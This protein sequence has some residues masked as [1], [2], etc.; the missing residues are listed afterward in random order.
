M[1]Q[2]EHLL[3][4][5]PKIYNL[6]HPA[7]LEIFQDEVIVEEKVDG[8][9]FSFGV[10]NGELQCR[11]KGKK[12][13]I[14]APDKL[15]DKAVETI[16]GLKDK[17]EPGWV[18]I[19]EYLCVSGDTVVRKAAAG[20]NK[21]GRTIR[22]L[23]EI[24][25][26]GVVHRKY[27]KKTTGKVVR[28][29]TR[30]R[31]KADGKPQLQCLDINK[32]KII[33]NKFKKIIYSG[34]KET[35][36]VITR[37]GNTIRCTLDHP[38]WTPKGWIPLKDLKI[39]DCVGILDYTYYRTEKRRYTNKDLLLFKK[40]K[41]MGKCKKCKTTLSLQVH[42][43]DGNFKNNKKSNLEILC[44][45]CH[46]KL[47]KGKKTP[48]NVVDYEFDKIVKIDKHE[49][50]DC[51]DIEMEGNE[52]VASFLGNDFILHNC[53]PKHNT[54]TYP[55]VPRDHII[56]FDIRTGLETYLDYEHKVIEADTIGLEVVPLLFKGKVSGVE[57]LERLLQRK[58]VLGDISI[59]GVVVKNYKRFANDGKVLMAKFVS[60]VFKEINKKDF[61]A[62]N[63]VAGDILLA[64]KERYH[65]EARWHKSIQHLKE[66]G[67]LTETV[68][69]I[70]PLI[71]LIKEDIKE[72]CSEEIK[73]FLFNWAWKKIA[74]TL[75]HGF[76]EF[77]KDLL[78]K[79]QFEKE[80]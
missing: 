30:S 1:I 6:G 60:E 13:M 18:Y 78:T 26:T 44:Q 42:H 72:E 14:E 80:E 43:K 74:G 70:G 15:F 9:Q 68:K 38:F 54:L 33:Y 10:L 23:Y 67:K 57:E 65:S 53:K 7:I 35:Y 25:E 75:V 34:K 69:D 29:K 20:K 39:N 45:D 12:Q 47:R 79:K 31:W 22:E 61:R 66:D 52:N 76:P 17:L 8:S 77:Y 71:Q 50:E 4:T 48:H 73:N 46:S 49:I 19:G 62:R 5:Y 55:R 64:I 37:K 59:E 21:R 28:Y 41:E 56:L 40:L 27:K 32:D 51:Y 3:Y 16:Q 36:I 2:R 11:S 58:S 63:P 24:Q